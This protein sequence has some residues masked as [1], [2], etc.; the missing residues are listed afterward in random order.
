VT[1]AHSTA[2]AVPVPVHRVL[3]HVDDHPGDDLTLDRLSAVAALSKHHLHRQFTRA[4]GMGVYESVRLVRLKRAV[5]ELAFRSHHGIL[6]IALRNG[7]SSHAAFSRAFKHVVGQTHG[8]SAPRPTGVGGVPQTS[9]SPPRGLGRGGPR[10]GWAMWRSSTSRISGWLRLSTG[11]TRTT[12]ATRCA[13]SS[14]GGCARASTRR[15]RHLQ[16]HHQRPDRDAAG[17]TP[18]RDLRGDRPERGGQSVR[19]DV[20]H[21]S[22]R[23]LRRAPPRRLR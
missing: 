10:R 1:T 3:D 16:H 4:C 6:D 5:W 17:Q 9:A 21:H 15:K 14:R 2:G 12:S 22:R 23:A 19:G 11:A 8:S 13:R 7:Y 18:P 20:A